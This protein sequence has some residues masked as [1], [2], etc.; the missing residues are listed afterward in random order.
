M[1]RSMVAP[2]LVGVL[3]TLPGCGDKTPYAG[4][5]VVEEDQGVDG[6][7]DRRETYHY[8]GRG[9]LVLVEFDDD[10]DDTVD[11]VWVYEYEAGVLRRE[12]DGDPPDGANGTEYLYDEHGFLVQ[13]GYD[14]DGDAV[15]D[16]GHRYV[17]DD[18]GR[19]LTHEYYEG[20]DED[21]SWVDELTYDSDGYLVRLDHDI[22]ADGGVDDVTT[23]T[24]NADH[25]D[26]RV[27]TDEG[28]D[29][30]LD[31]ID[32][33]QYDADGNELLLEMDWDGDEVW[34]RRDVHEYV[35]GR[36]VRTE[37]DEGADGVLEAIQIYQYD[38]A[39][40]RIL[41]A[42]YDGNRVPLIRDL[43]RYDGRGNLITVERQDGSGEVL[44][45]TTYGYR[46]W[47]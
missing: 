22:G 15:A 34:D 47:R 17:N 30:V 13:L 19:L 7:V 4:P 35:Q 36:L 11:R 32:H 33:H 27:E 16:H 20:F 10:A 5:C 12:V 40:R 46:C 8:D 25:T 1:H 39:G 6:T 3:V 41:A 38:A 26:E 14:D 29:G 28:S 42:Y 23:H 43:S 18:A 31:A 44:S 45:V 37:S 24:W 9:D 21:P 2:L